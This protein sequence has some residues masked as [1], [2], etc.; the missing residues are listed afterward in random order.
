M[1]LGFKKAT[2]GCE[3]ELGDIDTKIKIP[4]SLG[5]WD[6]HDSSVMNSNGTAND[7]K[8]ILNRYGGEIQ[9]VPASSASEL[10]ERVLEIY[11]LFPKRDMNF[12]TNL[13]VHVRIPG[14]IDD[15]KSLKK[16]AS[17]LNLY[18]KQFFGLIDPIPKPH[19]GDY[20]SNLE[21]LG[22][23]ARFNRRRRSHH[24]LPS[25]A[26]YKKL[27]E[28]STPTQFHLAFAPVDRKGRPQWH[29]VTRAGV[30]LA[31]L[32]KNDCVE[33]RCFTMSKKP[34]FLLSAFRVPLLFL[35]EAL[36]A[37]RHPVVF[38]KKSSL[39]FQPF[40]PYVYSQ[41]RIFQLT[42]V[43]HRARHIAAIN[44]RDLISDAILSK[45]ELI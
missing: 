2:I 25:S 38:L 15:L 1:S 36:G 33:F 5:R 22:A 35:W 31:H 14:L 24:T 26:V 44:Y 28:A 42:S 39:E 11:S 20:H 13:H 40:Y 19:F 34:K 16:I 6:Y 29:L 8:R 12:T 23:R 4:T 37:H 17:Y 9:V 45:K 18:G 7:P 41:D 27:M 32:W 3:L 43:R 10:V 30:N 21:Y